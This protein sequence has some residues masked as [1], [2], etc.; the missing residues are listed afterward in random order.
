M[1][2]IDVQGTPVHYQRTGTGSAVVLLHGGGLDDAQLSWGPLTPLLVG[3]AMVIA[4]DLPGFGDSPL[5]ATPP[6]VA[7]YASWLAAFLDAVGLP[8]CVLGGLSLGGAV[9]IRTALDAPDRVSG[10]LGCAPYG[11]DPRVPSGRLG[12]LAVHSPG[13]AALSWWAM[14]HS[15]RAVVASLRTVMRSPVDDQLLEEVLPLLRRPE[16]G[17]AWR[18]FQRDEVRWSGPHTVF[19][20]DLA[21]LACPVLLLSGEHDLVDPGAVRNA[22]ATIPQGAFALISDAGHW[23]PRDAPEAVADQLLELIS[24]AEP[25]RPS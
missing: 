8:R 19:G 5:G 21:E 4:P 9:A 24:A 3:R 12:W 22:A 15:R 6:T 25:P 18:A 2:T 13:I 7:G 20:A 11:I 16:A 23:L 10:V 14:R 17:V 1:P